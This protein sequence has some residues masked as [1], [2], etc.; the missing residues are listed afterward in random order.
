MKKILVATLLL[1]G[2]AVTANAEV[3]KGDHFVELD[4]KAN[5]GK[6]F[7]LKDM[8]GKWVVMGFNASW[9]G[10]CKKELPAVDRVAPK[11]SG[12]ALFIAVNIDADADDG[13]QF[14]SSLKLRHIFPVFMNDENS[15]AMKAYDPDRMPSMFVIDPKGTVQMV[16]YGYNK[17]DEDKLVAKLLELTK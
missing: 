6:A 8:A 12:K 1:L 17:G 15:A 9:C 11:L 7:R 13:K 3:K 16:E 5:N 2:S 14:I 10:P 4:A